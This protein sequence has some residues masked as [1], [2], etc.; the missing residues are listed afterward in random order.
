LEV[1]NLESKAKNSQGKNAENSK[2]MPADSTFYN[3]LVPIILIAL[4]VLM[5]I[6]ILAAAGIL[7]GLVPV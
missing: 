2:R 3:K 1:V 5:V 6:V 4:A 7:L